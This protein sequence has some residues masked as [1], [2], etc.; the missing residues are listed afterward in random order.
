MRLPLPQPD[1]LL[2]G[3]PAA[4]GESTRRHLA[5][6]LATIVVFGVAYGAVMGC[7]GGLAGDRWLQPVYSGVK[8]PLLLLVTFALSLPSFFV[9]NSLLGLRADFGH[10]LRALVATQA[11]LT[12]V[13]ASLAPLTAFWYASVASY[14]A[15]LLFNAAM[16]AAASAAGQFM[17]RRAYRPLVARDPRHRTLM[18]AWLGIYAFVGIQLGWVLRPFVGSPSSATRFFRADAWGN[19]YVEV[20]HTVGRALGW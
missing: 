9:V 17:L 8:V 19:A 14:D 20:A 4:T 12:V 18:R 7:F 3:D 13:L 11:G 15:A 2:R 10:V 6:L 16:F 1:A 5:R